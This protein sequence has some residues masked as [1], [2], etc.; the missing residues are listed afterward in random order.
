MPPVYNRRPLKRWRYVGVF[1]E[2]L[3][4]CAGL[5]RVGPAPQAFWAVWD[6]ERRELRSRTRLFRPGRFVQFAGERVVV[7]DG[8]VRLALEVSASS[9]V[10]TVSSHGPAW[11]WTRKDGAVR[12]QGFVEIGGERIA[13]DELGCVDDSAGYHARHTAWEWS[14]G[15]GLS[16][17]GSV[18]GWNL[19]RG[20]HDAPVGSERTV[21]VDGVPVEAPPVTFSSSL[22][23]VT[24]PSGD[25]LR[26][27][28]EARRA[29]KD[30]FGVVAS[31]YVQ[32]FGTF[33]GTLPG[34]LELTEG[35]G[36]MERHTARW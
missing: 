6:R 27:S 7:R 20:L 10:E 19:V 12:V 14:A 3:M 25:E 24:F 32:P 8:D 1:G 31:D 21:W 17:G 26:F 34:G 22:D 4:L 35:R 33:S 36:V 5:A 15:V 16:T 9:P 23:R 28:E 18:V 2:R 30:S 11:I 13:V 29:R